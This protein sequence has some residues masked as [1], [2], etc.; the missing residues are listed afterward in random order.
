VTLQGA[1]DDQ[2]SRIG[3]QGDR[4]GIAPWGDALARHD[5]RNVRFF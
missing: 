5:F 4:T 1:I 3:I 2:G